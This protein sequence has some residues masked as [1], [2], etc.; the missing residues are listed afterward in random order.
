MCID[1]WELNLTTIKGKFSIL[2]VEELIEELFGAHF[3]TKLDLRSGY[4]QI[5]MY[6]NDIAKTAFRT[7]KG[8]YEFVVIP[9]R[10][11][12]A[13]STFQSLMNI[14]FQTNLRRFILIFF[15]DILIF[16]LTWFDHLDHLKITFKTLRQHSLKVKKSKWF[17]A[18]KQVTN[19]EHVISGEKVQ[20][21]PQKIQ[22]IQQWPTPSNLK[23]LRDI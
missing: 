18:E 14:V 19:L 21:D 3:F 16:S 11:T 23:E 4:H 1:Y 22:A 10:L 12:N 20:V 9:F 8:H 7:H 2:L 17:F 6:S 15:D 13:P 5:R